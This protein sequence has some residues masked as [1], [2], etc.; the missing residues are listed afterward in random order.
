M[1]STSASAA[2]QG[3]AGPQMSDGTMGAFMSLQGGPPPGPPPGGMSV[4]DV[5][6]DIMSSLDT[7]GD[8]SISLEEAQANGNSD[9]ASA[10]SALDTNG[11][12][13]IDTDELTSAVQSAHDEMASTQDASAQ[14]TDGV[15][16]GRH[17]HHASATDLVSGIMDAADSDSSG[18]LSLDEVSS[19]LGVS[20]SDAQSGFSALDSDGDGQLSVSE[21]TSAISKYMQTR[22]TDMAQQSATSSTAAVTA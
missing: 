3:F 22:L 7:D 8:G 16:H 14:S 9:A 15:H 17:H 20:S 12:G 11:D 18:G 10:F 19:A 6:S 5:S 4:S 2:M 13:K 1:P 21:L